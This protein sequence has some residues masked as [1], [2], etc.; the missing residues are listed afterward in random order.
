MK[1]E[2]THFGYKQV[3]AQK[4]ASLVGEVFSSVAGKYDLMNDLM[5]FGLHRIWKDRMVSF[6]NPSEGERL[7]DVAGGTGDIAFR[8]WKKARKNGA[9]IEIT[10]CDINEE[11]LAQGRAKAIDNN[12]IEGVEW[13]QGDAEK[14]P[15]EDNSF[16]YYTIAFGIRNVTHIDKVLK[17]TYRV[18]KPGGQFVCMEFSQV[19]NQILAKAYEA[20][21]FKVIP[22]IGQ[23]VA[24]DRESYQ[25][26]VESIRKFPDKE[27]FAKM[28]EKAGFD[29]VSITS[30]N[31]GIVAIHQGW[32]I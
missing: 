26:L 14:L 23:M 32:K 9:R 16:D 25:Y 2:Q 20:Y 21:S 31:Q 11:M 19:K 29:E 5:S 10:V 7:L 27:K 13:Q 8:I 15:F 6:V 28:I 4:K 22:Q 18:L 3:D 17:E 1:K 12:I 30:L 24:G